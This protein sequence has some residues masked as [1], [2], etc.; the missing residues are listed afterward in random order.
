MNIMT[1]KLFYAALVTSI[2]GLILL[3]YAA[4]L[5]EPGIIEISKIDNNYLY[6]NV[7]V[8][9]DVVDLKKFN[10]GSIL[11]MVDDRTG[12]IGVFLSYQV[13]QNINF[14]EGQKVDVIGT[15]E[16]YNDE[17]EIV[18]NDYKHISVI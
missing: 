14:Q 4:N 3:T 5:L 16:I 6:K 1:N 15:V 13:G 2:A 18:V 7:H 11:L 12:T 9:G 17:L 10:S 8:R